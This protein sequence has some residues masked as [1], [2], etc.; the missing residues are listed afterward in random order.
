LKMT[1]IDRSAAEIAA[2]AESATPPSH[3]DFSIWVGLDR[4]GYW[5]ELLRGE[6][7]GPVCIE[8]SRLLIEPSGSIVGALIVT[9]M[10]P[11]DWWSGGPWIP[12]MFVIPGW[13]GR[14]LGRLLLTFAINA[15][16]RAGHRY[17]GL[18][19]SAA[20]PAKRLYDRFGFKAFLTRWA[21]EV[22]NSP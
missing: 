22:A 14:G 21:V 16:A 7:A 10:E 19:V 6:V 12:E 9:L 2:A 5:K 20:N 13:Q 18:T 4:V 15:C 11:S 17:L 3:V 8:P 1:G